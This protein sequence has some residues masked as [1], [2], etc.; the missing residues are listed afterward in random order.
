MPHE[1]QYTIKQLAVAIQVSPKTVWKWVKGGK[2]KS[3]RYGRQHRI[4][5]N[6]WQECFTAFNNVK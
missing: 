1:K 6:N 3:T 5:E 4:S 2:L